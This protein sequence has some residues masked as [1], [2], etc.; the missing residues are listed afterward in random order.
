MNIFVTVGTTKFDNLI[1]TVDK[2]LKDLDSE[3]TMQISNGEYKPKNFEFF[4]YTKDIKK[5][6][7]E[8]DIIIT[9]A[10]A[11]S[12]YELL[13]LE[14]KI[15]IVPNLDRIDKHQ[16]DIANYMDSNGY[17]KKLDSFDRLIETIDFVVNNNFKKFEKEIFF[18]ANEILEHISISK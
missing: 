15:I 8:S 5:Y 3:I 1:K 4:E 10:G 11:G 14:K 12:I 18:K 9:H 7:I 13:E 2:K 16:K 6:F 17:A